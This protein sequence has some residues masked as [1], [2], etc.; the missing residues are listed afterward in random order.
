MRFA[1]LGS[2]SRGNGTVV[3]S[4]NTTVLVDC[5]FSLRETEARLS[6]LGVGAESLSAVLVTHEHGDHSNGVRVL[7]NRYR[8]PVYMTAGTARAKHLSEVVN[9]IV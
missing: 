7:A 5:G 9:G 4:G 8:L 2:G 6:R 1:S 3:Q